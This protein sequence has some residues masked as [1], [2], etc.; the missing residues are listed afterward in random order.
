MKKNQNK[1]ETFVTRIK[2]KW[3]SKDKKFKLTYIILILLT[4]V[5]VAL[6][7]W[8]LIVVDQTRND[9]FNH[10]KPLYDQEIA[11]GNITSDWVKF[12]NEKY[13][14]DIMKY[15]WLCASSASYNYLSSI[16]YILCPI[17]CLI[18][19]PFIIYIVASFLIVAFPKKT[20]QEKLLLKQQKQG[21]KKGGKK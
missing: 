5:L 6:W 3:T 7:I 16:C 13:E 10:F 2:D 18:S 1:K 12:V 15:S 9:A 14:G 4:I 20:K 11:S 19:A 17:T 8:S 21:S